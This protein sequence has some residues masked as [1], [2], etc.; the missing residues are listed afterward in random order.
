MWNSPTIDPA[1]H[2]LY[3]GTGDAYT[4]PVPDTTD[5]IMAMDLNTGKILWSV[6]DTPNDIWLAG[7]NGATPPKI[8]RRSWVRITIS[9]LRR[10]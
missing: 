7:C 3:I 5:A 10:F 1:R 6:Q 8:V 2:A 9:G 4:D